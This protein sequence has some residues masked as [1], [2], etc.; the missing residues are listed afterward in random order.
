[1]A[2]TKIIQ[3]AG[4]A[5]PK[6]YSNGVIAEGKFLFIAGQI[7]W[8]ATKEDAKV[9]GDFAVQ[10]DL[11]LANVVRVLREAGGLPE[12]LARVTV[13]VTDKKAYSAA[14]KEIGQAW[15][16]HVGP[17]YPAMSLVQVADLLEEGAVVEIEATAVL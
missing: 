4:W 10:F 9:K 16:K 14:T 5:R 13:Y 7:G 8:D 1:M 17:V 15:R 3:P 2:N 12:H 11:A 6:G